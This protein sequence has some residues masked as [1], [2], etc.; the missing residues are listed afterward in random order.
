MNRRPSRPVRAAEQARSCVGPRAGSGFFFSGL[1]AETALM[2]ARRKD[3]Q[4]SY[5]S[6]SLRNCSPISFVKV[7]CL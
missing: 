2:N 5:R 7:F 1:A 3:C 4:R 6:V